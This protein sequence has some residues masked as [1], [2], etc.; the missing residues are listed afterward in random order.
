VMFHGGRL[1]QQWAVDMHMKVELMRLDWYSKHP[2][3]DLIHDD[4]YQVRCI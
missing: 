2:H 1:F 4:L 3:Q